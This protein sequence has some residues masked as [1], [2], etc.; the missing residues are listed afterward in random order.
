[1]IPPGKQRTVVL[2]PDDGTRSARYEQERKHLLHVLAGV[3][4]VLDIQHIGSTAVAGLAAKPIIDIAI[5]VTSFAEAVACVEPV[6]TLG[7]EYRGEAGIAGRHFFIKNNPDE[8]DPGLR[9]IVHLH[10]VEQ[11]SSAWRN[12]LAFRDALRT[13]AQLARRYEDLKRELAKKFTDNTEAYTSA[14]ADFIH[15]VLRKWCS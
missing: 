8:P 3:P 11:D 6:E 13:D 1:M 14:K 15:D 10:I 7:Y 9:R 4:W 12:Y 5:G 2:V